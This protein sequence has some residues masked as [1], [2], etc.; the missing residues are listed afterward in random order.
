MVFSENVERTD[1]AASRQAGNVLTQIVEAIGFGVCIVDADLTVLAVNSTAAAIFAR[2]KPLIGRSIRDILRA[3]WEEPFAEETESR[4]RSVLDLGEAPSTVL[5]VRRKAFGTTEF[6]DCKMARVELSDGSFGVMCSFYDLSSIKE[7]ELQL[8]QTEERNHIAHAAASV[9]VWEW[10]VES[11][12][13]FWSDEMWRLHGEVPRDSNPNEFFWLERIHPDDRQ[14]ASIRMR[15]AMASSETQY[16]DVYRIVLENHSFRWV[17]TIASIVRDADNKP[18]GMCGVCLDISRRVEVEE[19]D[20]HR[21]RQLQLITDNIPALASYIGTDERYRFVNARYSEWFGLPKEGILGKKMRSIFG[22]RA[23]DE[24]K[25]RI[26]SVL[27]GETVV[28]EAELA[29]TAERT[30]FI[31]A[32]FLPDTDENG[33]VRGFYGFIND[34]TELKRSEQLLRFNEDRINVIV[35]SFTDYAILSINTDLRIDSWNPGGVNIFGYEEHEILGKPFDTLFTPEDISRGVPLKETQTA[36]KNGRASDER[37]H[38]R[39]DGSRFFASGV[40]TPLYLGGKLTGYAK[41]VS[42]LTERKRHSEELQTA[43]DEMEIRVTERTRELAETNTE[44]LAAV[45]ERKTV[46]GLRIELLQRLITGQEDERRRIARDIHDQLGQRLTALR[47]KIASLR[48]LCEDHAELHA[49][50]TR[51]Q[52]IAEMLDSEISFLAWQ[53]R[54]SALDELGLSDAISTYVK[55]WTRHYNIPAWFHPTGLTKLRLDPDLETHLYRI[56]Q[57]ALHNVVKHA[58]ASRVNVLLEKTGEDIVLII[59]DDGVGFSEEGKP[60]GRRTA[61]GL[62]LRGMHER[63]V[64]IGGIVEIESSPGSGTT[65]YVRVPLKV[66]EEQIRE[67]T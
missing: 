1:D 63:A 5:T 43:Y 33:T 59:E 50:A 51:L 16:R 15:E 41:I 38:M 60:R 56:T 53:L 48:T 37:W 62:G 58:Q 34:V 47:L 17:E 24:L 39:K 9:G 40:I 11:R 31:N 28:F 44:L 55:E 27:A 29:Y 67:Q 66:R 13:I 32:T 10:N 45:S 35:D 30:R 2:K 20:R 49:R 57:E 8:A 4:L 19:S 64:L 25:P 46:E 14:K 61:K 26:E 54:P 18:L 22:K 12:Q 65:V 21:E 3:T 6:Y 42:D 52:E 7:S 23:Y 36:R